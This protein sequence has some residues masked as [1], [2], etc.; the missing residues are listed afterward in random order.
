MIT[1]YLL[2]SVGPQGEMD[3]E[4]TVTGSVPGK[5]DHTLLCDIHH[6]AEPLMLHVEAEIKVGAKSLRHGD[7]SVWRS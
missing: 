5:V 3:F 4:L 7:M 1:L 2:F 6:L